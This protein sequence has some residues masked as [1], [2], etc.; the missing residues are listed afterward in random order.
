MLQDKLQAHKRLLDS[1]R[2]QVC[3]RIAGVAAT[4]TRQRPC[5]SN[6]TPAQAGHPALPCYEPPLG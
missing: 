1:Q 4:H 6:V 2:E 5:T 3:G